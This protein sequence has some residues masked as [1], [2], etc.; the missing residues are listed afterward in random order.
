MSVDAAGR[1][2]DEEY[3]PYYGH[4]INLVTD[5]EVI[6]ILA[7]QIEETTAYLAPFTAEQAVWRPAPG[8]WNTTEIVGHPSR[9][10]AI[11]IGL[12]GLERIRN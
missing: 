6:D 4:Y 5:G 3:I 1:P 8:E 9:D 11:R 10:Q 7:R 2:A 12:A